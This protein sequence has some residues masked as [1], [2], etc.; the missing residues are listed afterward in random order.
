MSLRKRRSGR[1]FTVSRSATT[2]TRWTGRT[3]RE[4]NWRFAEAAAAEAAPG[5]LVWV[6]DYNLWLVPGYLR[7]DAARPAHFLLPP[8]TLSRPPDM[9]NV[10]PWRQVRSSK[11]CWPATSVGFHI[12]RYAANFVLGRLQPRSWMSRPC[13]YEREGRPDDLI[14]RR[15]PRSDRTLGADRNQSYEGHARSL[16]SACPVG[17]DVD[18]IRGARRNHGN[19]DKALRCISG[20]ELGDA[21]LILSVSRTDYTKGGVEQLPDLRTAAGAQRQDLRGKVRLMHV[22][23]SANRNMTAYE[24]DPGRDRADRRVA[25]T[26]CSASLEWQPIALIST[27]VPFSELVSYYRAADVAWITPLADG[28]N[29]VAKEFLASRTDNDGVLVLSEFA[30]CRGRDARLCRHYQPVL[31]QARWT[32]TIEMALDM[33]REERRGRM[34]ALRTTLRHYDIKAWADEQ[35]RLFEESKAHH[36]DGGLADRPAA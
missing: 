20:S 32:A 19:G 10:L 31:E 6:H 36:A 25:S 3:F 24:R 5:A 2:T 21:K 23:V 4:V 16:V 8:H 11:A 14:N 18:F 28:M 33:D 13:D 7:Q 1:S 12:P 29:M 22:S 9:F 15:A 35:H 34:R 17:V 26:A 27:A 30:G